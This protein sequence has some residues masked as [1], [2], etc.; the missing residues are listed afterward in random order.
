MR[1]LVFCGIMRFLY[2]ITC[3][4]L[5]NLKMRDREKGLMDVGAIVVGCE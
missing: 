2:E 4:C 1:F 5:Q 3:F